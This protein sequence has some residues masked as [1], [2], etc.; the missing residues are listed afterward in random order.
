[1]SHCNS[2]M[3]G[4][5][6]LEG[7]VLRALTWTARSAGSWAR[8]SLG[9]SRPGPGGA[10][11]GH[12]GRPLRMPSGPWF[13]F[14]LARTP[15]VES[16]FPSCADLAC[17]GSAASSALTTCLEG[18]FCPNLTRSSV[19]LLAVCRLSFHARHSSKS[20]NSFR[21]RSPRFLVASGPIQHLPAC[22][23]PSLRGTWQGFDGLFYPDGCCTLT[24][25]QLPACSAAEQLMGTV[26]EE[27]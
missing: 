18:G 11:H 2:Q 3:V 7:H 9:Q 13:A 15:G 1:M 24:T 16:F 20:E 22:S 21:R 10:D 5:G 14:H 26:V 12:D 4:D 6:C 19:M 17:L 27:L 8:V 25:C 23:L